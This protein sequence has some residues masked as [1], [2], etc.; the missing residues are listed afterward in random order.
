MQPALRTARNT[1]YASSTPS[2]PV[3]PRTNVL[4]DTGRP[5]CPKAA[6]GLLDASPGR[7]SAVSVSGGSSRGPP[8][9][10]SGRSSLSGRSSGGSLAGSAGTSSASDRRSSGFPSATSHLP[11]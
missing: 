7:P 1:L 6:T 2:A 3:N 4:R 8:A 5:G 9:A 11:A 10:S